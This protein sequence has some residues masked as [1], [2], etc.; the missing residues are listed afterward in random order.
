MRHQLLEAIQTNCKYFFKNVKRHA[1]VTAAIGPLVAA[2]GEIISDPQQICQTLR[3][4]Y[5]KVFSQPKERHRIDDSEI[6]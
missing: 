2:D 1:T 3:N 6:F 5:K 4:Q